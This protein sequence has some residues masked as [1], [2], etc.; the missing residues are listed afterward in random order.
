MT[1]KTKN[2]FISRIIE[3]QLEE[4]R[5]IFNGHKPYIGDSFQSKR[6]EMEMLRC[7]VYGYD[8]NFCRIKK[9]SKETPFF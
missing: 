5:L 7:I 9:E 1:E 2:D 3:L 6:N 4:V 8:S